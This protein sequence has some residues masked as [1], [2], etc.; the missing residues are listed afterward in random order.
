[1]IGWRPPS[2][3]PTWM[4]VLP[5][6]TR[7]LRSR[8]SLPV[9]ARRCVEPACASLMRRAG[10]D[11]IGLRGRGRSRTYA[12]HGRTQTVIRRYRQARSS[13]FGPVARG[14]LN[15]D[16][17]AATKDAFGRTDQRTWLTVRAQSERRPCNDPARS[18]E[19]HCACDGNLR[20]FSGQHRTL[21]PL[22]HAGQVLRDGTGV[23]PSCR[24]RTT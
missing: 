7:W 11:A 14:G 1:M 3:V 21:A 24:S 15:D 17:H 19:Q 8:R 10:F 12:A 2:H 23:L 6:F 4:H 20:T 5:W 16:R 9:T 18:V 22:E 13:V